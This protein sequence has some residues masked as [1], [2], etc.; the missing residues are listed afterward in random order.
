MIDSLLGQRYRILR[1]LGKGG[2]GAVYE[3]EDTRDQTHVAVK[4]MTGELAWNPDAVRRFEHERKATATIESPHIA[5]LIDSGGDENCPFMVMEYLRGE[6]LG[7]LFAR[8]GP[9]SQNLALRIA[10]QACLGLARAHEAGVVHRDIKPANLFVAIGAGDERIIKVLDFG[11]AKVKLDWAT[12]AESGGLTRTGAMLGSPMYMSPEQ[13]RG[14]R[15]VDHRADLWSLGVVLYEALSGRVPHG[16]VSGFGELIIAICTKPVRP[17]QT[18]APWVTRDVA[19]IVQKALAPDPN[20][21]FQTAGEMLAAI[22]A[23]LTDVKTREADFVSMSDSERARVEARVDPMPVHRNQ[24]TRPGEG[25]ARILVVEDNEM[26]ID[27]LSRRLERKGYRVLRAVD[28]ET[29]VA[30]A[31]SEVPDLVVMDISLPGM[32]GWAAARELRSWPATRNLPIIALTAHAM[33]GDRAK[34]L[35]AGCDEY[36]TKPVEFPRLLAKIEALLKA[37][38]TVT[39]DTGQQSGPHGATGT[40][41]PGSS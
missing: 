4:V 38:M 20:A 9:M 31:K 32:D 7:Q 16:D 36:E 17:V 28:G 27:M 10:A 3:A 39:V 21:R 2:M 30:I 25:G 35:D 6:D 13:A 18:A 41:K 19:A 29:G 22:Q 40:E 37:Q 8:I 34:A 11:V 15:D 5:R 14:S 12:S 23:L 1:L 26:N 33:A 24:S